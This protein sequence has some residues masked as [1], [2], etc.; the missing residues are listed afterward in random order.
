MDV[1]WS[2]LKE[3]LESETAVR[4]YVRS[5]VGDCSKRRT[6]EGTLMEH[7]VAWEDRL[8]MISQEETGL[9]P[10]ARGVAAQGYILM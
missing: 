7:R 5:L 3:E 10:V 4:E 1:A 6:V 8:V 9:S 2:K